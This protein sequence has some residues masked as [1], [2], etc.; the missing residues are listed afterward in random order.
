MN[1]SPDVR[2]LRLLGDDSLADLRRRLRQRFERIAPTDAP[3]G[4]RLERLAPHEHEAL[5][6]LLGRPA[7]RASASMSIDVVQIDAT[8][9]QVGI[10]ASLREALEQLDGPIVHRAAV[11]DALQARW[12]Q[13]LERC[14]HPGLH[15]LLDTAAGLGLLRRLAGREPEAAERLC[16][17]AAAVLR[18]L[19]A[20]GLP[21]AQLAAETLGDAHALDPGEPAAAL[22]LATWQHMRGE[23]DTGSA[24]AT[25]QEAGETTEVQPSRAE[26]VREIWASA[27][28]L[29]NELARPALFLN[30][31]AGSGLPGAALGGEPAYLSLR[32]LLRSPPRWAVRDRNV[33]VCENPNLVAIA[34]ARLGAACAPLVCTDGMPAAAQRLLLTQLRQAGARLLYHGDFDWP[35]LHIGN[36]VMEEHGARPWR[37]GTRDYLTASATAPTPGH[38]LR[39][40]PAD[41]NWDADLATAMQA[42]GL[43][44]AEEALAALLLQDL[45]CARSKP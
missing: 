20:A 44:I 19:P 21:R 28:V 35:G 27:G 26:S 7:A 3:A 31:P 23:P 5:A 38:A 29:V 17:R 22:V 41:A 36:R 34:A 30:L 8:L 43:A 25:M 42:H 13:A 39:G 33:H 45:A 10:A 40:P 16:G 18:R 6:R 32:A 2:L 37:F 15:G 1:P 12:Q 24:P 14:G 9:R 4:W 11:R